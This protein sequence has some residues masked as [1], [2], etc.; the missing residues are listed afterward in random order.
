M[1]MIELSNLLTPA[2]LFLIFLALLLRCRNSRSDSTGKVEMDRIKKKMDGLLREITAELEKSLRKYING[3]FVALKQ[4][5]REYINQN[6]QS[7]PPL[8]TGGEEVTEPT[9]YF[10]DDEIASPP[11]FPGGD[12]VKTCLRI[13]NSTLTDPDQERHFRREYTPER[14][15]VPNAMERRQDR[16][17]EPK[18]KSDDRGDF[19]VVAIKENDSNTY[20]VFPYFGLTIKRSNY[21]AGAVG[22][23]FKCPGFNQLYKYKIIVVK[24]P[25]I[26]T[27]EGYGNWS[28][29]TPGE[30]E[31]Y[32]G[33]EEKQ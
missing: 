6:I 4:E 8:P 31:I 5:M 19:I 20:A 1:D 7:P 2:V 27:P 30:L 12:A 25:A 16:Y 21:D 10:I 23:V 13:Y 22:T 3:K 29:V 32:T 11:D 17:L 18:F 24:K 33:D 15:D 28:L 14:I 26:F 9:A